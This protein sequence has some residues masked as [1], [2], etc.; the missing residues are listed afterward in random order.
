[1]KD[2][3]NLVTDV[4][5]KSKLFFIGSMDENDFPNIK[6]VFP[7]KE[8]TSLKEIYFSTNTSS[9]HAAQYR[10]NPKACVYFFKFIKGRGVLLTGKMEVLET[11]EIKNHFWNKG[12]T[13]YYPKG[14][15]DPDYCILKFT[16][17]CG[18]YYHQYK[19]V[20]FKV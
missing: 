20:D 3:L 16:P 13:K 7:V 1:M 5:K 17:I 11:Q 2:I 19:S 8:R 15:T 18:R 14:V 4:Y 9:K 12:D 6:V 10:R